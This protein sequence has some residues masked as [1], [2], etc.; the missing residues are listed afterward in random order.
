M[1]VWVQTETTTLLICIY[2]LLY[3]PIVLEEKK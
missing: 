2:M 3:Y 1:A